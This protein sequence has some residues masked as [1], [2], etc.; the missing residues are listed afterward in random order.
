MNTM[1]RRIL[2][3]VFIICLLIDGKY[4]N[5]RGNLG[6][7]ND[8][9]LY[10]GFYFIKEENTNIQRQLINT[11]KTYYIDSIPIVTISNF[12]EVNRFHEK[13]CYGMIIMLNS[14]GAKLLD[15][16]IKKH[17]N[18]KIGII[19]NNQLLRVQPL[20]D[21]QFARVDENDDSRIYGEVL[22]FPCNSFESLKLIE[23]ESM[24]KN[25]K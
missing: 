18:E 12:R 23:F 2:K 16:A 3:L 10:T 4:L 7:S 17:L 24:I 22:A 21:P 15:N 9:V 20:S 13:D 1:N 6:I 11:N 25:Y 5:A 8:K 14:E 19:V